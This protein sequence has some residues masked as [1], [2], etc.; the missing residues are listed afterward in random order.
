MMNTL[1]KGELITDYV[2]TGS[3][4]GVSKRKDALLCIRYEIMNSSHLEYLDM[5]QFSLKTT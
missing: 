5:T 1:K 2:I 3:D 4:Y